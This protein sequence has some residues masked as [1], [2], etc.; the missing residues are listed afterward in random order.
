MNNWA[1]NIEESR[2]SAV[3]Y[4]QIF[5]PT[6]LLWNLNDFQQGN[7]V[8]HCNIIKERIMMIM[9]P[10]TPLNRNLMRMSR[11][12]L[13]DNSSLI[14]KLRG[15]LEQRQIRCSTVRWI[16]S[17]SI[18]H[19]PTFNKLSIELL[20]PQCLSAKCLFHPATKTWQLDE[21]LFILN[22]YLYWRFRASV[23]DTDVLTYSIIFLT[24]SLSLCH[25]GDDDVELKR[26]NQRQRHS[27]AG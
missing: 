2:G 14:D 11:E 12:A 4:H 15:N 18:I 6:F 21:S 17:V 10:V 3:S 9:D 26:W 1:L 25:S 19:L 7:L 24:P 22:S 5:C 8:L 23:N 20:S 16:L 13:S 27:N